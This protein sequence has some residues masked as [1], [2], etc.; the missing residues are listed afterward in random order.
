[1]RRPLP[2]LMPTRS[3]PDPGIERQVKVDGRLSRRRL[4]TAPASADALRE[5]AIS[6][7]AK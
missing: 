1:M 2:E 7:A 3:G 5:A 6:T 4:G